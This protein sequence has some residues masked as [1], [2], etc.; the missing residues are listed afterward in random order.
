MFKFPLYIVTG[1]AL[2]GL[3]Q[4]ILEGDGSKIAFSAGIVVFLIAGILLI[5]KK[6]ADQNRS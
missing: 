1:F 2:Y 6:F 4:A 3:I 5:E